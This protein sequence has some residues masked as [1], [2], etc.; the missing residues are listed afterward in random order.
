MK[1]NEIS[2]PPLRYGDSVKMKGS[3]S[4]YSGLTGKIVGITSLSAG[5]KFEGMKK[6]MT[7]MLNALERA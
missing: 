6:A 1:V 5:V 3:D 2:E 4:K 7:I